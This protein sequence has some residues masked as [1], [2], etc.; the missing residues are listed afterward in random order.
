M[1]AS[2]LRE[3]IFQTA[4]Q[5]SCQNGAPTF[6]LVKPLKKKKT[7]PTLISNTVLEQ[8]RMLRR[9]SYQKN[10]EITEAFCIA[11]EKDFRVSAPSVV[12]RKHEFNYLKANVFVASTRWEAGA[13]LYMSCKSAYV[14]F[15]HI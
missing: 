10:W 11:N 3:H 15:C 13:S 8:T 1:H 4:C 5:G 9:F 6:P 2:Q 12:L 14:R 7:S